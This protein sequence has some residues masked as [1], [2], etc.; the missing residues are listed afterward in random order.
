MHQSSDWGLW[1]L[2]VS[3]LKA[4]DRLRRGEH[5]LSRFAPGCLLILASIFKAQLKILLRASR[6]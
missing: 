4:W 2:I 6:V 3:P 5:T 1:G